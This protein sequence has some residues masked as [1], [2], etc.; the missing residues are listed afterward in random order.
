MTIISEEI[1]K[2]INIYRRAKKMT[3]D[4]L[5]RKVC[6]SKSTL[7]KYEKGL[8]SIDIETLYDIASALNI[9][10]EQLLYAMPQQGNFQNDAACPAFFKNLSRFYSYSFDGRDRR[11]DCSVFDVLSKGEDG[12]YRLMMYMNIKSYDS[13][14]D[15]ENTYWGYI[16]HF[17]A[18]SRITLTNKDTPMEKAIIQVLASFL[19]SPTKW[20]LFTGFSSRPMMPVAV[21]MLLSKQ[22]LKEDEALIK[23]LKV[24]REDIRLL[25]LYNMM[26]VT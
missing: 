25:K 10:V 12:K 3:L 18:M 6:K 23:K 17:D 16:Q 14:Q 8:I 20:G 24:S 5:S 15:C 22:P 1:G 9:H 19:D 21:K 2:K 26:S 11:M 4:G 13:Y 7:S